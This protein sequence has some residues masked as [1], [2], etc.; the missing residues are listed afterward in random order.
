MLSPT[1]TEEVGPEF[2]LR[3]EQEPGTDFSNGPSDGER[4]VNR[5]EEDPVGFRDEFLCRLVARGG[6][7]G[8]NDLTVRNFLLDPFQER[9]GTEDLSDRCGMDP[10]R[11]F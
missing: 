9:D 8:Q 3:N 6:H 1:G 11:F 10:D 5:K 2:R 4:M 7:G